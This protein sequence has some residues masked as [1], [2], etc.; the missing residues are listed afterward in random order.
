MLGTVISLSP[1]SAVYGSCSLD[2]V[3]SSQPYSDCLCVGYL[4]RSQHPPAI[5]LIGSQ[6]QQRMAN[7]TE[8]VS[9]TRV[10]PAPEERNVPLLLGNFC[11]FPCC[12]VQYLGT[13]VPDTETHRAKLRYI[14][15]DVPFLYGTVR[16]LPLSRRLRC[17]CGGSGPAEGCRDHLTSVPLT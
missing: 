14:C 9:V 16:I 4:R 8:S 11:P 17:S 15:L 3:P 6:T 13:R 12:H 1:S 2:P 7:R 10:A 5:S